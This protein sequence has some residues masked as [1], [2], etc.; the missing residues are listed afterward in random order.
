MESTPSKLIDKCFDSVLESCETIRVFWEDVKPET[1]DEVKKY[2]EHEKAK[3]AAMSSVIG[4][5]LKCIIS[6][7]KRSLKLTLEELELE[8]ESAAQYL[9][10]RGRMDFALFHTIEEDVLPDGSKKKFY[11]LVV[12]CKANDP[13]DGLKQALLYLARLKKLDPSGGVRTFLPPKQK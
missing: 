4:S 7:V 11:Y 1:V 5:L 9:R 6:F 3:K 13:L 8:P 10:F 12:E 2:L